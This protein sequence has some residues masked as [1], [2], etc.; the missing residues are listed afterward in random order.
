[1]AVA[2]A[3]LQDHETEPPEAAETF[4][5]QQLRAAGDAGAEP[6]S[7]PWGEFPP[8]WDDFQTAMAR[9]WESLRR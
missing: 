7:R 5:E 1:M 9:F 3:V 6:E 4:E 8:G 2:T